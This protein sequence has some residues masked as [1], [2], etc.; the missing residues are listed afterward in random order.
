MA[1]KKRKRRRPSVPRPTARPRPRPVGVPTAVQPPPSPDDA[2]VEDLSIIY[3]H[4]KRDLV[5]IVLIGA[6]MFAAIYASSIAF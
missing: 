3:A 1:R 5:R 6:L 2:G 4:V